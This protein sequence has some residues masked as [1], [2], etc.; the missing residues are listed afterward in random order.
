M[1]ALGL[2]MLVVAAALA[3]AQH[4]YAVKVGGQQ[5]GTATLTQ[6][7][8]DGG[9]KLVQLSMELQ[10]QGNTV[11]ITTESRYDAKGAPV[12]KFQLTTIPSQ[13]MRRQLVATFNAEGAQVVE[14]MNGARKTIH[15]PLVSNA[16][17]E[18]PSEFWFIRDLPKAG[19]E[20]TLYNFNLDEMRWDV[21]KVSYK[22]LQ[23]ITHGGKKVR[24]HRT[25]S[26]LGDS[27]FDERGALLRLETERMVLERLP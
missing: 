11:A 14:E 21:E 26:S 23:T 4:R 20:I 7:I 9:T 8:L 15:R 12:R 22:G 25:Q 17:R 1:K 10:M 5:V 18:N 24:A 19:D 16:P 6:K 3:P 2:A 13:R 27:Y